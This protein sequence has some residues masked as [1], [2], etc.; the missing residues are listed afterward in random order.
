MLHPIFLHL[1]L[2]DSNRL[3]LFL[4]HLPLLRTK[5]THYSGVQAYLPQLAQVDQAFLVGSQHLEEHQPTFL[6][7]SS[8][9]VHLQHFHPHHQYL[10]E[11]IINHNQKLGYLVQLRLHRAGPYLANPPHKTHQLD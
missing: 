7:L 8:Q 10:V 1:C 4:V 9:L 2:V 11:V 5:Q 3:R 6:D